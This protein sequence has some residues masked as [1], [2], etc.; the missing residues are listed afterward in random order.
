MKKI[1]A[2]RTSHGMYSCPICKEMISLSRRCS[3]GQ[4]DHE[5]KMGNFPTYKSDDL[6][7]IKK[8]KLTSAKQMNLCNEYPEHRF[9]KKALNEML[10]SGHIYE[11]RK[12]WFMRT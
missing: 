3:C 9:N 7:L 12:G 5:I 4:W 2:I 1:Y 8:G 10:E 6:I 11:R